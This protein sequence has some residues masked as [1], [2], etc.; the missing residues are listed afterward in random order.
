MRTKQIVLLVI[1]I[2]FVGVACSL[3]KVEELISVKINSTQPAPIPTISI[4]TLLATPVPTSDQPAITPT[5]TDPAP[6]PAGRI[7]DEFVN[8]IKTGDKKKVAGIYVENKFALRVVYQPS[9]DA[10]F[11]S[12]INGVA[13][14][15][16]LPYTLAKNHGF[17]AHNFLS[18]ALFFDLKTGDIVQV[19]WGD[20]SYEDF[21]VEEI[22]QFQ[23]LSPRSPRSDFVDL[24][25]GEKISANTLFIE[26]YKGSFHIA[27]QTC[28]L[29]NNDDSWGRHFVLAPPIN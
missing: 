16:I 26:I 10:S 19:I 21:E 11:V 22:K 5:P 6:Q 8:T 7:F 2:S 29:R 17:L 28:I 15:F 3:I 25:S 13:T 12:T 20:G 23:A 14:Y 27:L 9:N 4:P 1:L 24:V 18:G